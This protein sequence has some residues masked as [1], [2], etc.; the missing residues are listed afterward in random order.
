MDTEDK[1][2]PSSI[3]KNSLTI[4][5][6]CQQSCMLAS[7]THL[8]TQGTRMIFTH[9]HTHTH[10]ERIKGSSSSSTE[11]EELNQYNKMYTQ[12]ECRTRQETFNCVVVAYI[13]LSFF[14]I[15]FCCFTSHMP[16]ISLSF[17]IFSMLDICGN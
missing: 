12:K 2:Q 1:I 5:I 14:L 6:M 10:R 17:K 15:Y 8:T 3:S 9:R 16:V 4:I 13:I 11:E 7:S